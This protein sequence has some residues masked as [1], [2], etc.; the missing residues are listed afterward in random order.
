[1]SNG[2]SFENTPNYVT[3][4]LFSGMQCDWFTVY[5]TCTLNCCNNWI[6]L[7]ILVSPDNKKYGKRSACSKNKGPRYPPW[8]DQW[9]V[10][11]VVETMDTCRF[12]IVIPSQFNHFSWRLWPLRISIMPGHD[13]ITHVMQKQTEQD[14]TWNYYEKLQ[15]E[16]NFTYQMFILTPNVLIDHKCPIVLKDPINNLSYLIYYIYYSGVT[17]PTGWKRGGASE[18]AQSWLPSYP[19]SRARHTQAAATFSGVDFFYRLIKSD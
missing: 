3:P 11:C 9:H 17:I 4:F 18:R 6:I 8:S 19:L 10:T 7:P 13:F 5:S 12:C 16:T 15:K 1:M 2:L 14:W